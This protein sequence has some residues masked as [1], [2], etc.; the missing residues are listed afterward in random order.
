MLILWQ[1]LFVTLN[2]FTEKKRYYT[3]MF[4]KVLKITK[5]ELKI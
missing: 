5:E 1:I 4:D 3:R 2:K